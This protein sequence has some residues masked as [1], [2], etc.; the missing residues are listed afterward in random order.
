MKKQ[1]QKKELFEKS[2]DIK[3]SLEERKRLQAELK[4][5]KQGRLEKETEIN[6]LIEDIM[7]RCDKNSTTLDSIQY[8]ILY[9]L[10][11]EIAKENR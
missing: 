7:K 11:Q 3:N 8:A 6:K 4:G 1:T 10:K 5:I 9:K 2:I